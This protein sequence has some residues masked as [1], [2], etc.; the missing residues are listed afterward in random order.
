MVRCICVVYGTVRPGVGKRDLEARTSL[1]DRQLVLAS[2][3]AQH[4][5]CVLQRYNP[6]F[7][8]L[9]AQYDTTVCGGRA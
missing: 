8:E 3:T 9:E 6:V 1:M 2:L 5:H 7:G 4:G